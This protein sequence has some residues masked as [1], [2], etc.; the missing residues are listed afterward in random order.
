MAWPRV[1]VDEVSSLKAEPLDKLLGDGVK[2][3][4]FGPANQIEKLEYDTREFSERRLWSINTMN[5]PLIEY[6]RG[7]VAGPRLTL[8]NMSA[9][10]QRFDGKDLLQKDPAFLEWLKKALACV[11][12]ETPGWHKYRRY[13]ITAAAKD[14]LARGSLR[15]EDY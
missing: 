5:S 3:L 15:L 4:A 13:R 14:A 6:Q 7:D 1:W 12:R 8:S 2:N 11:K 9:Y 10:R